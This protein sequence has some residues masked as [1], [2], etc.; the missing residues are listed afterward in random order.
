[1]YVYNERPYIEKKI[2]WCKEHGIKTIVLDNMS[3]DGTYEYL[4]ENCDVVDRLDT[5]GEFHLTKLLEKC[6][7]MI[8][9][10]KPDWVALN[11]PDSWLATKGGFV[12]LIKTVD[13]LGF[14]SI[15]SG[16]YTMTSQDRGIWEERQSRLVM[17]AK[18]HE[19]FRCEADHL[20]APPGSNAIHLPENE[21][22]YL[23]FGMAKPKKER[24]VTFSRR[25]KA[26]ASGLKSNFGRHY[27]SAKSKDW[28]WSDEETT[29]VSSLDS[30]KNLMKEIGGI[31]YK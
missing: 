14:G 20:V 23:N 13:K 16:L 18:Y 12:D 28:E 21:A 10:V 31:S 4:L 17:T 30:H 15:S 24:E 22:V 27:R 7:E 19:D 3:T 9:E 5:N 1:M 11:S 8:H 25:K 2:N 29:N 26:W 6:T